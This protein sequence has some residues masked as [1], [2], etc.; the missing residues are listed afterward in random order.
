MLE[1]IGAIGGTASATDKE[2]LS[3]CKCWQ[4]RAQPSEASK[5]MKSLS[6][7]YGVSQ[8]LAREIT[9]V[10]QTAL[11][12]GQSVRYAAIAYVRDGPALT[13]GD[14]SIEAYRWTVSQIIT[15]L[16]RHRLFRRQLTT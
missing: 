8:A 7:I 10:I 6:I 3:L 16:A 1:A 15:V 4:E 12:L 2:R 9:I 5:W 13:H 14:E 11:G